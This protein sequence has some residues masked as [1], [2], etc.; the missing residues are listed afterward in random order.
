MLVKTYHVH[1]IEAEE[2][3]QDDRDEERQS[4]VD[5]AVVE[6]VD[7]YIAQEGPAV[8]RYDGGMGDQGFLSGPVL[9]GK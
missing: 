4:P 7:V 5:S 8:G 9:Q 2:D 1:E 3:C 6:V